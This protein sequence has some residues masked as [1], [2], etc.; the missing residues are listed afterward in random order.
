MMSNIWMC[1]FGKNRKMEIGG[2]QS[3]VEIWCEEPQFPV[4]IGMTNATM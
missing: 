3:F 4:G 2:R 1:F